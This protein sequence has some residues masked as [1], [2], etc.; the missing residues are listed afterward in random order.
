MFD[1]I[2]LRH[3]ESE[4]NQAGWIQGQ[5]NSSLTD[6]G[7]QQAHALAKYWF[8][9]EKKFDTAICS[10]LSRAIETTTIICETIHAPLETDPLWQERGFGEIE[11]QSPEKLLQSQ[12]DLDFYHPFIP[13]APGAESQLDLF[14]RAQPGGEKFIITEGRQLSGGFSRRHSQYGPILHIWLDPTG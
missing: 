12:P 8:V 7:R 9:E 14:L 1:I 10:T 3:G 13:P 5:T 6:K 4:G 11:G 2:F